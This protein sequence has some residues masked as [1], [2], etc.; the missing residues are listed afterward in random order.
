MENDF[1]RIDKASISSVHKRILKNIW[2][3]LHEVTRHVLLIIISEHDLDK[4]LLKID[5]IYR[6]TIFNNKLK[7]IT[8]E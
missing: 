1:E 4:S 5:C 2:D 8:N 7:D 3:E 6:N